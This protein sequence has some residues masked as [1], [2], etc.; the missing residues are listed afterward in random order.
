MHD[1]SAIQRRLGELSAAQ[2]ELAARV[3]ELQTAYDNSHAGAIIDG[4]APPAQPDELIEKRG[5][6]AGTLKA[7]DVL[8][9]QLPAAEI[10]A[11]AK[12]ARDLLARRRQELDN[13]RQ[14]EEGRIVAFLTAVLLS[15][16]RGSFD[17]FDAALHAKD[18]F[19]RH[20]ALPSAPPTN[21]YVRELAQ[22]LPAA[23]EQERT[24]QAERQLR[25]I[26]H[27]MPETNLDALQALAVANV[28]KLAP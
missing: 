16:P 5:Q 1:L 10:E 26:E 12:Q 8:R 18:A 11:R 17:A 3:D 13:D 22:L 7:I 2:T 21:A 19:E 23:T 25:A 14:A 20:I 28:A 4:V 24:D 9:R 6:L 15:C 27:A